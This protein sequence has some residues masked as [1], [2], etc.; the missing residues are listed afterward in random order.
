[1]RIT[2]LNLRK[3]LAMATQF[4]TATKA[5]TKYVAVL[6]TKPQRACGR[7]GTGLMFCSDC[8]SNC[9]VRREC[10]CPH[11][12]RCIYAVAP[13]PVTT[14]TAVAGGSLPPT[15][16]TST[17]AGYRPNGTPKS[18][19]SNASHDFLQGGLIA[20]LFLAA[21][22]FVYSGFSAKHV[23]ASWLLLGVAG[24]VG[25]LIAGCSDLGV[26]RVGMMVAG[27]VIGI[28]FGLFLA[29]I[30]AFVVG[31]SYL[32]IAWWTSLVAGLFFGF[33]FKD[34]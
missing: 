30:I 26:E 10:Y 4:A 6:Q 5:V 33:A 15:P 19:G 9:K 13:Q 12:R 32:P 21:L 27:T 20:V 18:A 14:I 28:L 34:E 1:V 3:E 8:Y 16:P 29:A 25:G 24:V 31:A 17:G 22:I 7:C 2:T 23:L 11:C